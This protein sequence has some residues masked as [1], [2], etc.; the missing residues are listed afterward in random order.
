MRRVF[1]ALIVIVCLFG[2]TI[3]AHGATARASGITILLSPDPHVPISTPALA[4]AATALTTYVNR[5][6]GAAW[7]LPTI[8]VQALVPSTTSPLPTLKTWVLRLVPESSVIDAYGWHSA[9][10]QGYPYGE[11]GYYTAENDHV[12]WVTVAS[13]ELAEMAVDPLSTV[14]AVQGT[15]D[16]Q[17]RGPIAYIEELCDPVASDWY[18]LASGGQTYVMADFVY[19]NYFLRGSAYPFDKGHH[20]RAALTPATGGYQANSAVPGT[21]HF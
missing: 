3:P 14:G 15:P 12:S 8:T 2:M 4:E 11:V 16:S 5:D 1:A 13:H 7:P 10:K 19:P 21:L 6:V 20:V 9:T 18:S 17:Q